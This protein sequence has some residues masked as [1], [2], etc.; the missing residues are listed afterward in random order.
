MS[1]SGFLTNLL[2]GITIGS[3]YTLIASG[4]SIVFGV[5]GVLNFAHGSFVMLGAYTGLTIMNVTGNFWLSLTLAPL[6]VALLGGIVERSMV[7]RLY[8]KDVPSTLF[9]TFGLS[10]VFS[11][12]VLLIWGGSHYSIQLPSYFKGFINLAG[13]YY[14]KFRLFVLLFSCALV[15]VL[16]LF[17]SR[18]RWGLPIRAGLHDL[19]TVEAFGIDIYRVFSVLFIICSGLAAVAGVIIGS[20]RS[21][22]PM[23][24]LDL[25]TVA[26]IVI[27]IGGLGSFKGA[28]IGSLILGLA[29][30]FGA[31]AAPGFAKFTTWVIMALVLILRPKGLFSER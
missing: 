28:L 14:P 13:M 15:A 8:G 5:M 23:M 24:D 30:A 26:L 1:F 19:E 22:N 9:L 21:I 29:E 16:W 17:L 11:N 4:L 10:M 12:V 2:Y 25:I 6:A 3:A 27:V 20:M 7:S 18:S 31:Q